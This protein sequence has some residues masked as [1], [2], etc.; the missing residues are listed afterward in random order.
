MSSILR[1]ERPGPEAR[2]RPGN[3]D[4]LFIDLS[5]IQVK[6]IFQVLNLQIWVL[7]LAFK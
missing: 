6:L 1:L 5:Y 2:R 7:K 3:R 4:S